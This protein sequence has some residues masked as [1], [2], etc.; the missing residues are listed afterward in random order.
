M[1]AACLPGRRVNEQEV[2]LSNKLRASA[3]RVQDTL[4]ALGFSAQVIELPATIRSAQEAAQAIGC[5]VEPIAKSVVFRGQESGEPVLV[6]ASGSNRVNEERL[7]QLI[8]QPAEKPSA[9]Y[10]RE[11]TGFSIGGVPPVGHTQPIRTLVDQALTDLDGIWAAAGTP[12]AVFK[13]TPENL[14]HLTGG[15]V[16][17][18]T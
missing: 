11:R 4:Q 10:V 7:A 3:Q 17:N 1:R 6:I 8:G 13:L 18:I 16:V 15:Q 5:R 9:E 12:V 14:V 2:T